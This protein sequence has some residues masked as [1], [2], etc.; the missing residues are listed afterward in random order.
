MKKVIIIPIIGIIL[1]GCGNKIKCTN[2]MKN[3]VMKTTT[4]YYISKNKSE[5]KKIEIDEKYEIYNEDINE[6]YDY[7]LSFRIQEF[8]DKKIKYDYTHKD[9]KYNIKTTYDLNTMDEEIIKQFINTKDAN[10]YEK[11]LVENGYT[12]K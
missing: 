2:T 10:E 5:I 6:N 9:N 7:L 12:C 3:D 4:T 1:T 11:S 8:D